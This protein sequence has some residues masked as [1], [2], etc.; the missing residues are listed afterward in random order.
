M[1]NGDGQWSMV[2]SS[3]SERREKFTYPKEFNRIQ[4]F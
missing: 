2:N 4:F 1:V 3:E